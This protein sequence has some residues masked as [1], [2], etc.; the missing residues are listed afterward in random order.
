MWSWICATERSSIEVKN[1]V[2][3]Y[4]NLKNEPANYIKIEFTKEW[5]NNLKVNE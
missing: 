1:V 3:K 4:I 5:K 2:N